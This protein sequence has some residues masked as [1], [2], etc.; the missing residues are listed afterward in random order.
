MATSMKTVREILDLYGKSF[1]A[2]PCIRKWNTLSP[3]EYW[4]IS[5]G[6]YDGTGKLIKSNFLGGREIYHFFG[7]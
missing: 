7:S 1:A 5:S 2:D 3:R 6:L 4:N